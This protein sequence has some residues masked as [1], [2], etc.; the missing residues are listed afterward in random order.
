[1]LGFKKSGFT[2]VEL[3]IVLVIIGIIM[4]MAIKGRTLIES[5]K[6]RSEVRKIEKIQASIA[7]WFGNA[8]GEA[9]AFKVDNSSCVGKPTA[10]DKLSCLQISL[11]RDLKTSDL[12]SP[13][14]NWSLLR[15]AYNSDNDSVAN[16]FG[17][18]TNFILL[19]S[20]TSPRFACNVE[21][22]MDDK[23]Y[24]RSDGRFGSGIT[25]QKDNTTNTYLTC[26]DTAWSDSVV[27]S[28]GWLTYLVL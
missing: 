18:G 12:K 26:D 14:D 11:L 4:G 13:T 7:G 27:T 23:N 2:F 17:E 15:G 8:G 3:A 16:A 21:S 1:M 19:L 9:S 24:R 22:M 6:T 25:E 28:N 5:A 20:K 10:F